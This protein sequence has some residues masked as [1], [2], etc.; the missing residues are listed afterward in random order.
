MTGSTLPH[1]P[2]SS[3]PGRR[4][5]PGCF[6]QSAISRVLRH[7]GAGIGAGQAGQV[8]GRV[9]DYRGADGQGLQ[10]EVAERLPSADDPKTWPP[11]ITVAG[12]SVCLIA[13]RALSTATASKLGKPAP[14]A[15]S[16]D[17]LVE[18]DL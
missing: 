10:G 13:V 15:I 17:E 9:R 1:T 6:Q 4:A 3:V 18:P 12:T 7:E 11:R 14:L 2:G 8:P 5:G 16:Y